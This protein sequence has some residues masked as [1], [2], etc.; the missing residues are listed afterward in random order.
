MTTFPSG[1]VVTHPEHGQ[2]LVARGKVRG[3]I[4]PQGTVTHFIG[5][6]R[7]AVNPIEDERL[8]RTL[9]EF[10][11]QREAERQ[12]AA[13]AANAQSAAGFTPEKVRKRPRQN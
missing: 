1:F 11:M 10:A 12:A 4:H 5:S 8:E 13:R 2:I 7:Y 9:L 3:I 6:K